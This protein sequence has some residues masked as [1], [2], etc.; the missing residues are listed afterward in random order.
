MI[1][2]IF[3]NN[4]IKKNR[5][6]DGH[7]TY[8]K[9]ERIGILYNVDEFGPAMIYGYRSNELRWIR[10]H[11]GQSPVYSSIKKNFFVKKKFPSS[12]VH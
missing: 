10:G 11:P 8:A 6:S 12:D 9:S 3:I 7:N 4:L 5:H 1:K 2:N